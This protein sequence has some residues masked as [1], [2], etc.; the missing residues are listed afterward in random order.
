M[1]FTVAPIHEEERAEIAQ[2]LRVRWGSSQ[3]V[4]HGNVYTPHTLPGFVVRDAEGDLVGLV[5]YHMAGDACEIVTIDSVREGQGIGS[6]LIRAVEGAASS[7]GCRRLW[8]IT[9]NDNLK[10]L[11][12]YQ[13]RG[14][15]I[16]AVHRD[17]VTRSREIKPEIPLVGEHGIPLRDELE[18]EKGLA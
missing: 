14:F 2:F 15:A 16:V 6:A 1:R 12:F 5:T 13:K 18:L 11:G 17:A 9:T 3:V 10:A 4:A 7:A 8:L